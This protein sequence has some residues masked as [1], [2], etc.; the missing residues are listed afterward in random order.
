MVEEV[1]MAHKYTEQEISFFRDLIRTVLIQELKPVIPSGFEII[2][3][4]RLQTEIMVG[5]TPK[6]YREAHKHVWEG[7]F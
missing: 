1:V 5:V 7:S 4:S 2:V 3:E 6:E